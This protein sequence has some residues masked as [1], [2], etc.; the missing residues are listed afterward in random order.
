[1]CRH[2]MDHSVHLSKA[3]AMTPRS[4]AWLCTISLLVVWAAPVSAD[5]RLPNVIGSHMVLQRDKPLPLWGWGA[6]GEQVTVTLG[7][8]NKA[9]VTADDSGKWMVKL[10][11]MQAGGPLELTV[12]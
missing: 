1:M 2:P 11:A 6:P 3:L 10:A 12:Q 7:D 9:T 4:L 5:I 8:A